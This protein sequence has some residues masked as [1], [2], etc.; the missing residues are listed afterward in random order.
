MNTSKIPFI[1]SILHLTDFSAASEKAFAHALAIALYRQTEF[2]ILN[3]GSHRS[4]E[5]RW[6]HLPAV[7]ET[8]E[9][10]NLLEENSPKSAVFDKLGVSVKKAAAST[11]G[12][13]SAILEYVGG[14]P[15]DLIVLATDGRE[16]LPQDGS[17]RQG[18]CR[19]PDRRGHRLMDGPGP[20][21]ARNHGLG[22][23]QRGFSAALRY[24]SLQLSWLVPPDLP[25]CRFLGEAAADGRG[26]RTTQGY[27]PILFDPA[28]CPLRRPCGYLAVA[29]RTGQCLVCH[30][31]AQ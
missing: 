9:R 21:L 18:H 17:V 24:P 5:S 15:V 25:V 6:Q 14:N 28:D 13:T 20:N 10:W 22:V 11:I 3:F 26:A 31:C 4:V 1:N 23:G 19:R 12:T 16:G 29:F 8:L 7:R 2:T 30:T 27:D